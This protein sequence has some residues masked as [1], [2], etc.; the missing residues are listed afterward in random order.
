MLDSMPVR[1]AERASA[2]RRFL[3]SLDTH[4]PLMRRLANA[5]KIVV[6]GVDYR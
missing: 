6:I 5:G 3:N 1:S 4:D 2:S